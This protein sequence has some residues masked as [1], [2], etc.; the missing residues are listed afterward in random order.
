MFDELK[1][2]HTCLENAYQLAFALLYAKDNDNSKLLKAFTLHTKSTEP[3]EIGSFDAFHLN[4]HSFIESQAILDLN[5]YAGVDELLKMK[6]KGNAFIFGSQRLVYEPY[7][8]KNAFYCVPIRLLEENES[9]EQLQLE[10]LNYLYSIWSV[11]PDLERPLHLDLKTNTDGSLGGLMLRQLVYPETFALVKERFPDWLMNWIGGEKEIVEERVVETTAEEPVEP[12]TE[13]QEEET[14]EKSAAAAKVVLVPKGKLSLLNAIGVNTGRSTLTTVRQYFHTNTGAVISQKQLNDLKNQEQDYL[15]QTI[16][17][18]QSEGTVFSSEDERLYWLR[19][20]YNTLPKLTN[21]TPLPYIS[22]VEGTDEEPTFKYQVAN[23]SD[24]EL[25]YFDNKQQ[26]QLLEKFEITIAHV[27]ECLKEKECYFT[28]LD[29]KGVDLK[30]TKVENQLDI[31]RLENNSQEWGADHYMKWRASSEYSIHLYDGEIP[32]RV[33][34][35]EQVVKSYEQANAVLCDK[36]AYVNSN[37]TNIEEDLFGITKYN[38][39]TEAHLLGLL[40]FKNEEKKQ[41]GGHKVIERVV[42]TVV[43]EEELADNEEAI[44]NPSIEDIKACKAQN[45]KG[46]LKVAFDLNDLPAD[47]LDALLQYATS[48]KMI[49]EKKKVDEL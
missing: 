16:L 18:L 2:D 8:E 37:S 19:K 20:L 29:I 26:R 43:V 21:N 39:L 5:Y 44:E 22:K 13:E 35:L 10:L 17:W 7:I 33:Y 36:I 32:Y 45:T 48:T 31:E 4:E 12:E 11:I 28:N 34:F 23:H 47:M 3:V 1:K 42:E 6:E 14:A 49:V 9:P 41:T 38:S 27:F 40:R 46:K 25:Y 30:T 24:R 15:L